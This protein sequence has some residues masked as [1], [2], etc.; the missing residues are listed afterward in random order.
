MQQTTLKS[1]NAILRNFI[2]GN[3]TESVKSLEFFHLDQQIL[4]V[5]LQKG[6]HL[7]SYIYIVTSYRFENIFGEKPQRIMGGTLR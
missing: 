2:W 5:I 3:F 6:L 7:R 4:K 1:V